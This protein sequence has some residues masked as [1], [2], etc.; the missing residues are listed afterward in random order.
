MDF[1]QIQ[2]D[3]AV[4]IEQVEQVGLYELGLYVAD[5]T[6]NSIAAFANLRRICDQHMPGRYRIDLIDIQKQP[7]IAKREQIVVI[8]SVVRWQPL[9]ARTV[10]GD[11]S[12]AKKTLDGLQLQATQPGVDS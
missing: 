3:L 12:N 9:P 4:Q 5:R 10:I 7:E 8:P 11:L 1:P 2:K 6:R